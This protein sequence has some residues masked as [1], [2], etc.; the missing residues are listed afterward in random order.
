MTMDV[1]YLQ[2]SFSRNANPLRGRRL[3]ETLRRDAGTTRLAYRVVR[4]T[5][6]VIPEY[7]SDFITVAELNDLAPDLVFVEGGLVELGGGLRV[8][9][10]QLERLATA[11]AVVIVA[12]VDWNAVNSHPAEYREIA[13]LFGVSIA[14]DGDTPVEIFDPKRFFE[15]ERQIV[16]E[17]ADMA[18]EEW[19]APVY[20]GIGRILSVLPVP[21]TSWIE[22]VATCNRTTTRGYIHLGGHAFADPAPT[23]TFA[24]ARRV[25]DGYLVLVAA[26]VSPDAVVETFSE[27]CDWLRRLAEH[28]VDRVRIDRRLHGLS[29]QV[30]LSHRH[31]SSA[32]VAGRVRD[33]LRRR[34]FGTWLDSRELAVGDQLSPE[35]QAAVARSSHFALL[36]TA[37]CEGAH[38]I[39][40]EVRAAL[41]AEKRLII[42]RLDDSRLPSHLLDRLRIEGQAIAPE[43]IGR[44]MAASIERDERRRG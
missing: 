11:G 12:D 16:C 29:H 27:N 36:W 24:A 23:S 26:T 37:D 43:E 31:G 20:N 44:L 28:L 5:D 25:G 7:S 42:V 30:F 41:D 38:W 3:Y 17:P 32:E 22:L 19:L 1:L 39:D 34:G 21:L 18:Y 9:L 4:D 2:R 35:V 8:P 14:F 15:G 6:G 33:E 10:D 13:K 40:L